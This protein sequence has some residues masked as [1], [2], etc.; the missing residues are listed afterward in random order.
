MPLLRPKTPL[1]CSDPDAIP[2]TESKSRFE[3]LASGQFEPSQLL[4]TIN[5]YPEGDTLARYS[6]NICPFDELGRVGE[7]VYCPG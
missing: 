5:N 4:T 2:Q 1:S 7:F 6:G 3:R